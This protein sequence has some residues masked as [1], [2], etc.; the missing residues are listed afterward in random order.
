MIHAR[1]H[2]D[3]HNIRLTVERT[4]KLSDRVIGIGP[5][6]LGLD[7][8]LAWVPG[9]GQAYS[10]AA[11]GFLLLQAVRARASAPTLAGMAALLLADSAMST[12]PIIGSAADMFFTGHKWAANMLLK[13]LDGTLYVEGLPDDAANADILAHIRTGKER[14]R[15]VFLGERKEPWARARPVRA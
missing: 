11:G 6:G 13:H 3:L 2:V 1:S 5:L 12:A 15:V 7:G 9:A 8:V 10:L 4:K 14:R